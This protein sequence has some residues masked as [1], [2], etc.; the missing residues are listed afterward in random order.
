MIAGIQLFALGVEEVV[1][2]VDESLEPEAAAA[3][4]GGVALYLLGHVAFKL[5]TTGSLGS[6]RLWA[7][8]L[9]A[10]CVPVASALSALAALALVTA[11]AVALIAY[12][13]IR[14]REARARV[15]VA[16]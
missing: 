5:R 4:C 13:V 15:R 8:L 6:Q 14:F 12:E 16:A 7:A 10:A 9:L 2:H 11:V 1:G 3:L